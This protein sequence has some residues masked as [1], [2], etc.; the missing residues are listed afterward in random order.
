MWALVF[1]VVQ[2]VLR[3]F[4]YPAHDQVSRQHELSDIASVRGYCQKM[5][6]DHP[7]FQATTQFYYFM[8]ANLH[9][10][11]QQG[12]VVTDPGYPYPMLLEVLNYV[13]Q[14]FA[15][16]DAS[17]MDALA[18]NRLIKFIR[19]LIELDTEIDALD[20]T[21]IYLGTRRDS[22]NQAA[23]PLEW[24]ELNRQFGAA[25]ATINER[26]AN[27]STVRDTTFA[28]IL[29]LV[30]KHREYQWIAY[31]KEQLNR[32]DTVAVV[33]GY[34][35]V[36]SFRDHFKEYNAA[37]NTNKKGHVEVEAYRPWDDLRHLLSKNAEWTPSSRLLRSGHVA[38]TNRR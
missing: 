11:F 26:I 34:M 4:R 31:V 13:A 37:A 30:T 10:E 5:P 22:I 3:F 28:Q 25:M 14:F 15:Q 2:P 9:T 36:S 32:F 21:V 8:A 29:N 12:H 18:M 7:Y 23:H 35:H 17:E 1:T 24:F 16:H 38:Y 20:R 33:V 27:R 19:K 6:Q